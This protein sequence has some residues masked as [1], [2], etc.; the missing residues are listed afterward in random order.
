MLT[1][2]DHQVKKLDKKEF[3]PYTCVNCGTHIYHNDKNV[4]IRC[5]SCADSRNVCQYCN[6]LNTKKIRQLALASSS[7]EGYNGNEISEEIRRVAYQMINF[8]NN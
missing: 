8:T 5:E 4:P 1:C 2:K 3:T 7:K 6:H